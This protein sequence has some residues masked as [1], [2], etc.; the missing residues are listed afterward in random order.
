MIAV[1]EFWD[2]DKQFLKLVYAFEFVLKLFLAGL[3]FRLILML[4][5]STVFLQELMASTTA[6]F[7]NFFGFETTLDGFLLVFKD[8][9]FVISQDCL[10][11]KSIS[12]FL[13]LTF[14]SGGLTRNLKLLLSS[15][16]LIIFVNF[17]RVVSTVVLTETGLMSFSLT[18]GL[19][20]RW[21]LSVTVI[22]LWIIWLRR[23]ERRPWFKRI[24]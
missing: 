1:E 24:I 6:S 17:F 3:V 20:G 13:G 22:G 9:S 7:L 11:W 19:F 23:T 2:P 10:G 15:I 21:I 12:L 8:S 5:P 18:H 4:D 14:A 16:G